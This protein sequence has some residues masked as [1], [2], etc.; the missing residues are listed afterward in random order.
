MKWTMEM[1]NGEVAEEIPQKVVYFKFVGM[2][3][4][5]ALVLSLFKAFGC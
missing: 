5:L 4:S 3:S 1:S 2:K